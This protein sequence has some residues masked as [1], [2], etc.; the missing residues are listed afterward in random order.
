MLFVDLPKVFV[1]INH[2]LLLAKF[3]AYGFSNNAM[4]VMCSYFK[5][6]QVIMNNSKLFWQTVSNV[7]LKNSKLF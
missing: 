1:T 4:N 2:D 3:R 5:K 7:I 6:Q